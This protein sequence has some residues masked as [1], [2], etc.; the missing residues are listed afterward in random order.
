MEYEYRLAGLGWL[1]IITLIDC[2]VTV[3]EMNGMGRDGIRGI[4]QSTLP[5][6]SSVPVSRFSAE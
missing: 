3:M 2:D 6:S 4:T 5:Y 1:A